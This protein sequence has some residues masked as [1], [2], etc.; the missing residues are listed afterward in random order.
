V[1]FF[2]PLLRLYK[3]IEV[4][5]VQQQQEQHQRL[6][7]SETICCQSFLLPASIKELWKKKKKKKRQHDAMPC[8]FWQQVAIF[9]RHFNLIAF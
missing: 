7:L 2:F 4:K 1:V 8:P 9:V 5:N 3:G 6:K